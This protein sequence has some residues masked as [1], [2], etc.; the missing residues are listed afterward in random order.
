MRNVIR[1]AAVIC[2][3]IAGLIAGPAQAEKRVALAI[4]ID[5]YDN[6]PAHEQLKKAVN[7]AKAMAAALRELGFEATVEEN[8]ARLAFTRAWQRFLNR[9]EPGDTAA[10]FFAGHGVEIGGL[11][12]LLPRDVPKVELREDRVLAEASIR[13]NSLMDDLRDKKVRVALFIVDACRDNPFRDGRGRSVGG[14]RGLARVEPA[15]GSFVM[16]SAGAGE[17]ALD[18]LSDADGDPNS[19]YTRALLPI[20]ALPG[21]SLPDIATRVRRQVV[22]VAR[23]V[24]HEQTP[25]YYDELLGD[26]VL[27]AGPAP[28]P[29]VPP[30]SQSQL[31]QAA[32]TWAAIKDTTSVAA[33]EAFRRQYGA[34]NPIYDRLAEARIEELKQ[35][36]MLKAEQDR[37]RAEAELSRPGRIFRDCPN[38]PEMVVVP[39]GEFMMGS[40]PDDIAALEK[41]RA[42]R[43]PNY[44]WD[45]HDE[46]PQRTVR[47]DKAF[48]VGKFE[49][50]FDEWD[51]CVAGGGCASNKTPYDKGWSRGRRPV[52]NVSWNDAK[53]YVGWLSRT[54][55]KAYRLLSEAE[56]EYAARAGTTTRYW[57]GNDI[58]RGNANCD[59]CGSQWDNKQTAPVGSFRANKFGLH[60]MHGN[61]PEWVEDCGERFRAR[62][63]HTE[64]NCRLHVYRDGSWDSPPPLLRSASVRVGPHSDFRCC[65]F[66]F[67][68]AMT[69]TP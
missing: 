62:L 12:Y 27:K 34:A 46:A 15:K 64:G 44:L 68:V 24:R 11:N 42:R 56:W 10:L 43:Y 52:I 9:L 32:L 57:W 3:A 16:Y 22:E 35:V 14:T 69:L 4:G 59:G 29:V 2:C 26:F 23:T 67:R 65:S 50:T 66:G 45:F 30:A 6:L 31:S 8:V 18:R 39:A 51:A 40:S 7:D 1:L 25:A 17:R 49:V 37:K 33:L 13:F 54:T 21:L 47:I 38:C 48:A 58:G 41:L 55:G 28:K 53:E 36:A 20:L 63:P 61:A 5:V 19:L 60:D